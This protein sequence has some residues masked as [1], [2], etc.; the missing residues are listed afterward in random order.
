M[1]NKHARIDDTKLSR[2]GE[3][4]QSRQA[5]DTWPGDKAYLSVRK[6]GSNANPED[7]CL[8]VSARQSQWRGYA[9]W[10]DGVMEPGQRYLLAEEHTTCIRL[11]AGCG[12][13]K[14]KDSEC[15]R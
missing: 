3:R 2:A 9:S 8:Y 15:M 4:A 6:R 10:V 5:K 13:G 12:G 11:Y 7:P 14:D 1:P